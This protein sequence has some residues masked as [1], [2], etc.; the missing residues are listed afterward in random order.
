MKAIL[1]N[2]DTE[3]DAVQWFKE[4]DHPEVQVKKEMQFRGGCAYIHCNDATCWVSVKRYSKKP[5]P[6]S[7]IEGSLWKPTV[8]E[9]EDYEGNKYYRLAYSFS[10]FKMCGEKIN[11]NLE[12]PTTYEK[13]ISERELQLLYE[14]CNLAERILHPKRYVDR[15]D[16][17][18]EWYGQMVNAVGGN[19]GHSRVVV[20]AGDWV[21]KEGD[22]YAIYS[23]EEFLDKYIL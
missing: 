22:R 3:F 13:F 7:V 20:Y 11:I 23:N 8:F 19:S 1:K 14:D 12:D 6:E 15:K 18:P 4:G 16:F 21:V 2:I 17:N 9:V 5:E 10:L